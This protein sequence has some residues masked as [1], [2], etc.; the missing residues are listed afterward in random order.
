MSMR[1][2][3]L[4]YVPRTSR[5]I[6]QML[7]LGAGADTIPIQCCQKGQE[8]GHLQLEKKVRI[9]IRTAFIASQMD[10]NPFIP[11]PDLFPFQRTWK[12]E[13]LDIPN[14]MGIEIETFAASTPACRCSSPSSVIDLH[15]PLYLEEPSQPPDLENRLANDNA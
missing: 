8:R 11:I 12:H 9:P 7:P 6:G 10:I 2:T 4:L 15:H 5:A 3:T 1:Q 13:R 14:M